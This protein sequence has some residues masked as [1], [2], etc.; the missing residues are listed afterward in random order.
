MATINDSDYHANLTCEVID[1][2]GSSLS[3]AAKLSPK[4][5][6][7]GVLQRKRVPRGQI[8]SV[9]TSLHLRYPECVR[10]WTTSTAER[11]K[12]LTPNPDTPLL[13]GPKL[14]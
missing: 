6:P 8:L 12:R 10:V 2:S 14:A 4:A 5:K 9:S 3:L 1:L 13:F 7:I 11:H